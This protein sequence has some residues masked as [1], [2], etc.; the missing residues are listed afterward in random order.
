MAHS[1]RGAPPRLPAGNPLQTAGRRLMGKSWPSR[2]RIQVPA[3]RSLAMGR[4]RNRRRSSCFLFAA[5]STAAL[6]T[7]VASSGSVPASIA[8]GRLRWGLAVLSENTRRRTLQRVYLNRNLN[9]QA[10]MFFSFAN[11]SV[12]VEQLQQ[13]YC[14][15]WQTEPNLCIGNHSTIKCQQNVKCISVAIPE[16]VYPKQPYSK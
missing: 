14:D 8:R 13:F 3:A 2:S 15:L 12:T 10:I 16:T 6:P 1:R 5:C 7:T 11:L 4:A 9:I